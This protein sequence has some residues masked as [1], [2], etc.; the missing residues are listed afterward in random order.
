MHRIQHGSPA[1]HVNI[2]VTYTHWQNTRTQHAIPD[3][4]ETHCGWN[5][6]C[7]PTSAPLRKVCPAQD[8]P[9]FTPISVMP[10]P[11]LYQISPDSQQ[12]FLSLFPNRLVQRLTLFVPAVSSLS[13]PVLAQFLSLSLPDLEGRLC[14]WLVVPVYKW[15]LSSASWVPE[16][17]A[18]FGV[19]RAFSRLSFPSPLH[20]S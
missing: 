6:L 13:G 15:I 9:H 1:L 20:K 4:W 17:M 8:C 11:G 19:Y 5:G 3:T 12:N 7:G 16:T 10:T 14:P 2:K 18:L